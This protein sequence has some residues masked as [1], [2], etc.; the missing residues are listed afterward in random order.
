M[1]DRKDPQEE[2]LS[3]PNSARAE[4][5]LHLVSGWLIMAALLSKQSVKVK[6]RVCPHQLA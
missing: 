4:L 5:L 6:L 1:G 2:E 3:P